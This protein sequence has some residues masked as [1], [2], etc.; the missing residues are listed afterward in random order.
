MKRLKV[1]GILKE[2]LE[3][4]EAIIKASRG[5]DSKCGIEREAPLKSAEVY[6]DT[7]IR[8]R[9]EEALKLIEVSK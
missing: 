1:I 9:I 5:E 7:W 8:Y 2:A 3:S 4:T 6:I